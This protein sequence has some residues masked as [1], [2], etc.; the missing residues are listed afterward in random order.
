MRELSRG[1]LRRSSLVCATLRSPYGDFAGWRLAMTSGKIFPHLLDVQTV[2]LGVE[3]N[4]FLQRG[5]A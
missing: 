3:A 4:Q 1:M 2:V 5:R